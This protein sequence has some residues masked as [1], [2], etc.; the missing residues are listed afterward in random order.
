V[1]K[2]FQLDEGLVHFNTGSVG[3]TPRVV[4]DAVCSYLNQLEGDQIHNV[5]GGLGD[6]AE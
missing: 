1:R 6:R 4:T 5:W 2:E 3:A